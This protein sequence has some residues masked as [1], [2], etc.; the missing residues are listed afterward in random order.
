MFK[1]IRFLKYNTHPA[2]IE[3]KCRSLVL[4]GCNQAMRMFKSED[5]RKLLKFDQVSRTEQDRFFNEMT[6]TN[7]IMLLLILD[8]QIIET[9]DPER[10]EH[11]KALREQVPKFFNAFLKRI[12]IPKKY[13]K[14]WQ[15]LVDLRYDEYDRDA[16]EWR[17]ALMD[18][19]Y[20]VAT[21]KSFMIFQTMAFGLY[22][23]L[24]RGKVDS[25]DELFKRVQGFLLPV[26]KG[27]MKKIG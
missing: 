25:K 18:I 26:Y 21:E 24:R 15:K 14:I 10:K 19:N 16:I 20:E 6:V 3:S 8:K 2:R 27:L 22:H 9:D 23:H 1:F 11:L 17:G 7:I 13:A 4:L 5:I 12:G